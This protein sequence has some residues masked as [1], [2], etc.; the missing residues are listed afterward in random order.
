MSR[1]IF[2]ADSA[3]RT[4]GTRSHPVFEGLGL[5]GIKGYCIDNFSGSTIMYNVHSGNNWIDLYYDGLGDDSV[6]I[7]NGNYTT[8]TLKI[9]LDTALTTL[10]ATPVTV[11][12][13]STTWKC[14]VQCLGKHFY[15]NPQG[16]HMTTSLLPTLGFTVQTSGDFHTVSGDSIFNLS[17]PAIIHIKCLTL[18]ALH[19][20][21]NKNALVTTT[22]ILSIPITTTFGKY[23][24]YSPSEA[25]NFDFSKSSDIDTLEFIL[26]DDND[27]ELTHLLKDWIITLILKK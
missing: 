26:T 21:P 27:Q 18:S 4:S 19:K 13:D 6:Q 11:T 20:H 15:L 9:A 16:A 17:P 14:T 23:I 12:F 8:D 5:E 1:F 3:E 10:L 25:Y 7:T 2:V 24:T 22:T